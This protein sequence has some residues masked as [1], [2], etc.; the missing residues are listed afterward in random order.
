VGG[1]RPTPTPR[2]RPTAAPA[3]PGQGDPSEEN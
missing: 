3:K 1:A 2:T